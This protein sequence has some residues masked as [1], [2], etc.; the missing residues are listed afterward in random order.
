MNIVACIIVG[1]IAGWMAE[2]I[3]GRDHGLL[4]NLVVG[5]I[6]ALIGGFLTTSLLGLRYDEGF[7]LAS[8]AVAT[9]GAIVFLAADGTIYI[10]IDPVESDR[11]SVW[12]KTPP[13]K[14][15]T[16][17]FEDL[18]LDIVLH[19]EHAEGAHGVITLAADPAPGEDGAELEKALPITSIARR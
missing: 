18:T 16:T 14:T 15:E 13:D 12:F 6:G 2:R 3:M 8:I 7:N 9:L 19:V 5:I 17:R 10:R 11:A 1:L 4:M